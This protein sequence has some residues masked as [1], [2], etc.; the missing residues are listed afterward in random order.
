MCGFNSATADFY[1]DVNPDRAAVR[2][3]CNATLNLF[4][5]HIPR[6]PNSSPLGLEI[7][8]ITVDEAVQTNIGLDFLVVHREKLQLFGADDGGLV[9]WMFKQLAVG[10][11]VLEI[12][13]NKIIQCSE[14]ECK[15]IV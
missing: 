8:L 11:K 1:V 13:G 9:T 2:P 3:E 15:F 12:R 6:Y 5:T 7:R 10:A 4:P 14:I